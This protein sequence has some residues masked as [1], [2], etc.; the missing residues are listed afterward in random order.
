MLLNISNDSSIVLE[1]CAVKKKKKV[2][3]ASTEPFT[4]VLHVFENPLIL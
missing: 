4:V 3:K 1:L 2:A